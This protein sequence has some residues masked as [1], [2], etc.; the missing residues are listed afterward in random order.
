LVGLAPATVQEWYRRGLG[1]DPDRPS[2]PAFAAFAVDISRARAE[3][4]RDRILRIEQAGKGGAVVSRRTITKRD[5]TAIAEETVASPQ[6]T[7][8][9][10][11]AERLDAEH[12]GRK[13]RREISAVVTVKHVDALLAAVLHLL[14]RYVPEDQLDGVIVEL[15]RLTDGSFARAS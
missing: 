6:W 5:G 10:W 13:D 8:D 3:A 12:W 4:V 9:A 15:G 7:A 14:K 1:A 11:A 2:T